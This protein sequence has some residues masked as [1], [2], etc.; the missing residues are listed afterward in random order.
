MELCIKCFAE[1]HYYAITPIPLLFPC[2]IQLRECTV[3]GR[4]ENVRVIFVF[5]NCVFD[6]F[7]VES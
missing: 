6:D 1:I 5:I 4:C 2:N 7:N 3:T